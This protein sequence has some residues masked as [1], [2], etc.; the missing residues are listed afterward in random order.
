MQKNKN[1]MYEDV[2][3]KIPYK[4]VKPKTFKMSKKRGTVQE[5]IVCQ[6]KGVSWSLSIIKLCINNRIMF[7]KYSYLK[8]KHKII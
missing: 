7:I 4:S 3:G 6:L 1:D 2:Y 5:M 8:K